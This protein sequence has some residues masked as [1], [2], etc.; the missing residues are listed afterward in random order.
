VNKR[1]RLIA[2]A[3]ALLGMSV[4]ATAQAQTPLPT[5]T[6]PQLK[7]L[8]LGSLTLSP[9]TTVV[10]G[11]NITGTVVLLRPAI[12][13]MAVGLGLSDATLIEGGI[14]VAD[15]AVIPYQVTVPAG[16]DRATFTISTSKPQNTT[17]SKTFT[18]TAYYGSERKTASFTTTQLIKPKFP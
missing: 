5:K 14:Y 3:A 15:G 7:L 13:N 17:G 4:M 9:A 2:A 12:S 10:Q 1:L 11:S 18:V 6:G 8:W 16:S